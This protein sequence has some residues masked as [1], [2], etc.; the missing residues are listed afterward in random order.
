MKRSICEFLAHVEK[1]EQ[2]R[3]NVEVIK[4]TKRPQREKENSVV[5][6]C[7]YQS[8][9]S[10]IMPLQAAMFWWPFPTVSISD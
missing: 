10:V 8:L 9:I 1:C 7:S 2:C 6:L 4:R 5:L 3:L